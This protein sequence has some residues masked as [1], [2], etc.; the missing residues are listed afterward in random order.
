MVAL[1]FL[2]A[3]LD[4]A[5]NIATWSALG[6]QRAAIHVSRQ[7]RRADDRVDAGLAEDARLRRRPAQRGRRL[8]ARHRPPQG[9][10]TA[11]PTAR[12]ADR[13]ARASSADG[14]RGVLLRRR[15]PRRGLRPRRPRSTR[16]RRS[17]GPGTLAGRRVGRQLRGDVVDPRPC[18]RPVR[19]C[20]GRRHRL[21]QRADQVQQV[22]SPSLLAQRPRRARP[23]CHHRPALHLV[24]RRRA[25]RPRGRRGLADR[26]VDREPGDPAEASASSVP[27]RRPSTCPASSG[28][29]RLSLLAAR[30]NRVADLRA[31]VVGDIVAVAPGGWLGRDRRRGRPADGRVPVDDGLRRQLGPPWRPQLPCGDHRVGVVV[32]CPGHRV[33]PG[34]QAGAQPGSRTSCRTSAACS[35]AVAGLVWAGKV[36]TDAATGV[37]MLST[38]DEVGDRRRWLHRRLPVRRHHPPVDPSHLPQAAAPLVRCPPRLGRPLVFAPSARPDHVGSTAGERSGADR[39]L[40]PSA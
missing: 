19:T 22:A 10:G 38:A 17:D 24:Q 20:R 30:R 3:A 15:D 7:P 2:T 35:S 33:A 11:D 37:G 23:L 27:S 12:S 25:R 8:P 16:S 1:P 31:P 13:H 40:R 32:R 14:S 21:A 18:R 5:E 28:S 6:R 29:R 4:V 9:V 34:A 26:T 36:A 39:V